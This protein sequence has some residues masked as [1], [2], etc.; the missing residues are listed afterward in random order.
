MRKAMDRLQRLNCQPVTNVKLNL[1]CRDEIISIL[2]AMQHI[3]SQPKLRDE[4]LLAVAADVNASSSSKRGRR[5]LDYWPILVLAGVRLGCNLDY[6][7]LQDL[8]EQHRALRHIMGIGD[9]EEQTC[10]DWR[11]I[12]DN[13]TLIRPETLERINHLI[14]GEGHRLV[15]VATGLCDFGLWPALRSFHQVISLNSWAPCISRGI[16]KELNVNNHIIHDQR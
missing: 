13:L 10:F 15:P 5:G 6:D 1:A 8:A 4:I 16:W 2:A 12:Q 3:Y 14:V 9:W 11:R 7:K